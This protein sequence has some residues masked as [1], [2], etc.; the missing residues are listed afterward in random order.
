MDIRTLVISNDSDQDKKA[1]LFTDD[2]RLNEDLIISCSE[3]L[4][5][6]FIIESKSGIKV[7]GIRF[8]SCQKMERLPMIRFDGNHVYTHSDIV[9]RPNQNQLTQIDY[10]PVSPILIGNDT[11]WEIPIKSK[12]TMVIIFQLEKL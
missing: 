3:Q 9:A 10:I 5:K 8:R 1:H 11:I 4:Y 6:D 7:L 12:D 2:K